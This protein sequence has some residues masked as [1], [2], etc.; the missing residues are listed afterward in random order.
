VNYTTK[1]IVVGFTY[2]LKDEYIAAGYSP[3]EAAEFDTAE[4][5]DGITNALTELGYRVEKI[6]NAKNLIQKLVKDETWDIIFNICEGL[7]GTGREAQVPAILDLYNIPY[8]FSDVLVLSLTLHKGMTK[9]II[10][11]NQIPTSPFFVAECLDDLNSHGLQFPLFVKPVAEGTGKGIGPDSKVFDQEQL[12]NVVFDRITRFGQ[13]VLV[14]EFLPGREFTVGI[15]GTGNDAKVIGMMEVIFNSE[16]KTGIYSYHNKANYE[17]YIE[18]TVPE[19]AVYEMCSDV[20]IKAWKVLG[21]RDG[22]R[23]DLR[24]D[25]NGIPNF[26]EV[27]PLAGLN[28]VHSDLPILAYKAGISYSKLIEMIMQSALK[29]IKLSL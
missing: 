24:L 29:R 5:I 25:K 17:D 23:I 3:E 9:H 6:G 18:Y 2:D 11:D 19:K 12:V 26:I 7:N 4:T 20:A 1:P 28:P 22:G 16:E 15:T 10:K 21:C 8:V 27:N 13:G 14:E